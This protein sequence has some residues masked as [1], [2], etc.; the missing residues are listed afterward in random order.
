MPDSLKSALDDLRNA[1][2]ELKP[3]R[4]EGFE[5]LLA[6]VLGKIT[7]HVFRLASSGSQYGKDGEAVF[8]KSHIAFEGKLYKK[9]L[10]KNEVLG[11]ATEIIGSAQPPDVWIL[12]ATIGVK[13]QILDPLKSALEKNAISLIVLDWPGTV[14]IPP[15]ACACAL[16]EEETR[17]FL[18][19][20]LQNKQNARSAEAAVKVIRGHI[21]FNM[22][23]A[24]LLCELQE[25]TLGDSIAIKKNCLWLK[26]AFSDRRR[27]KE[28]FG[29][30]L[31]PMAS[32][33]M[34]ILDRSQLQVHLKDFVFGPPHS[35]I[36]ALIGGE[37]CGKSWLFA[38]SWVKCD[39]K[40]L[41]I[42]IPACELTD[43]AVNGQIESFFVDQLIKQTGDSVSDFKKK[44]WQQ[45]F[46]RWMTITQRSSPQLI[47]FI[48]GLNQNPDFK[49][50]SW[51]DGASRVLEKLGGVLVISV[52]QSYFRERIKGAIFSKIQPID[53]PEWTSHELIQLLSSR[54]INHD[55]VAPVVAKTLRNPRILS[56][57]FELLDNTQIES[58]SELSVERLLFEHIRMSAKFGTGVENPDQFRKRLSQHAREIICRIKDQKN[59]DRLVFESGTVSLPNTYN[60]SNDLLAVM[61]G[62]FYHPLTDDPTLYTLTED[63][64]S[65]ALGI[66]IVK[67]LLQAKRNDIDLSEKLDELLDPIAALDKS[68]QAVFS[69]LLVSCVDEGC[70][71]TVQQALIEAFLR[72]QNIDAGYY[73]AFL[74]VVRDATDVALDALFQLSNSNRYV[75]NKDWL[76]D[77]LRSLR[78]NSQCWCHISRQVEQWL[79]LYSLAPALSVFSLHTGEGQRTVQE[80]TEEKRLRLD[81]RLAS[82]TAAEKTFLH[83]KMCRNDEVDPS[84]ISSEAFKL[85]AGMPLSGFSE[86]L[87]AWSFSQSLNSS[88]R[89]PYE[90]FQFL[91]RFNQ[92]DWSKTRDNLMIDSNVFHEENSSPTAKWSFL[93]IL[94]ATSTVEDAVLEIELLEELTANIET[95]PGGRLVEKYCPNDPC[96]PKS[97]KPEEIETTARQYDKIDFSELSKSRMMGEKDFFL[98]A[99]LPGVARFASEV[100]TRVHR[101]LASE[102]LGREGDALRLGLYYLESNTALLV[103]EMVEMLLQKAKSFSMPYD[104]TSVESSNNWSV[105]QYSMLIAFP[106]LSGCEQ[107]ETLMSLLSHGQTTLKITEVLKPVDQ[108]VLDRELYEAF[109]SGDEGKQADILM[110]AS[111]SRTTITQDGKELVMK[112]SNSKSSIVRGLAFKIISYLNDQSMLKEIANGDWS[113]DALDPKLHYFE[114]WHGS[115]ALIGAGSKGIIGPDNVIARISPK[116]FGIAAATLGT[117][118][119]AII[120]ERINTSI[121]RIL[122]IKLEQLPPSVEQNIKHL[123]PENPPLLSLSDNEKTLH[124]EDFFK[125]LSETPDEFHARQRQGLDSFEKFEQFL[126]NEQARLIIEDVGIEAI[127]AMSVFTKDRA[128]HWANEFMELPDNKLI[129]VYNI[130]VMLARALSGSSPL[131]SKQLFERINGHKAFVTL[132]YGVGEIPFDILSIWKSADNIEMEALRIKRLDQAANDHEIAV[133]VLAAL[134]SGKG[135][136][137]DKYAKSLLKR[138]EP[139]AMARAL[140]VYGLGNTSSDC[141]DII[142]QYIEAQGL[143][144]TA[145]KAARFSYDRD[146]WSRYWFS[147]MCQTESSDEFWC[148][149]VLFLKIVDAR[150]ELWGSDFSRVGLPINNFGP[151]LESK[152]KDRVKNWA[153]KREKTLFGTKAPSSIFLLTG[154]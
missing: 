116:L 47:V 44:R 93:N 148:Y 98:T 150:F 8:S 3:T 72:L 76:L 82:M 33:H 54:G 73:L 138:V 74:S 118:A 95:F 117:P 4:A 16:A 87:V 63:G 66:S 30:V 119:Y 11:K 94:R 57:A 144:G 19:Q 126:T 20:H 31:A 58:F 32:M 112:L 41:C 141:C 107:I 38:Q 65:V 2:L 35:S 101:K 60:L 90:E 85:L 10:D 43:K 75:A 147:Q 17:N 6:T 122:D 67:E 42:V 62:Q 130:A 34:P 134:V 53:I 55:K 29:Q 146:R 26:D 124:F 78:N 121:E 125:Q 133:E 36:V 49:W 135:A 139:S 96:D 50:G 40:P 39:N 13:T 143:I 136:F 108:K 113:A 52:R 7:G 123:K 142:D 91:V 145:A 110:F 106:H 61:Q 152:F 14:T 129:Y 18:F 97:A 115:E 111:Y 12:G 1:L 15:L 51:L 114:V 68:S 102:I 21:N 77:A 9:D 28:I 132:K 120:A 88:H 5:G 80:E 56:I 140:I 153:K 69:A 37:G 154:T 84:A 92:R 22:A 45:H 25:P 64:L 109:R 23:S 27:A 46:E 100:A 79:R 151:S 127:E 131:L 99:A 89:V 59:E 24:P 71:S 81:E 105:S 83:N 70:S 86:A 137:I 48:D 149:S 103:P 128:K 104:L